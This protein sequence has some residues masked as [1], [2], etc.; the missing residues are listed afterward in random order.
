MLFIFKAFSRQQ[1]ILEIADKF[2]V[3]TNYVWSTKIHVHLMMPSWLGARQKLD[4]S[5]MINNSAKKNCDDILISLSC[6]N[7]SSPSL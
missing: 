7:E 5:V 3:C 6:Q 1:A 4:F 2:P